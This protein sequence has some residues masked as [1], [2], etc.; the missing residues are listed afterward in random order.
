MAK[1]HDQ[2]E[3]AAALVETELFVENDDVVE[4]PQFFIQN[5]DT[6]EVP[7]FYIETDTP[8]SENDE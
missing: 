2:K 4:L 8:E 1:N 6:L 3:T 7:Q 5:T